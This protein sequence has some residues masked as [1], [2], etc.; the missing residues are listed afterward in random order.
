MVLS[1]SKRDGRSDTFVKISGEKQTQMQQEFKDL[2]RNQ[3]ANEPQSALVGDHAHSGQVSTTQDL[4]GMQKRKAL[5]QRNVNR[6]VDARTALANALVHRGRAERHE[7]GV[8]ERALE[9]IP[10]LIHHIDKIGSH[11][12]DDVPQF[13]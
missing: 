10:I 7:S 6:L 4:D 5:L 1:T 9:R 13:L 3:D 12:T 11:E 8:L 2:S